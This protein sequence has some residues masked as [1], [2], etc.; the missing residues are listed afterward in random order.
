MVEGIALI[1]ADSL[2]LFRPVLN[3]VPSRNPGLIRRHQPKGC[4]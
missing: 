4:R 2:A 1:V 3:I